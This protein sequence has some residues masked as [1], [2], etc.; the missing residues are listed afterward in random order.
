MRRAK[1]PARG[2]IFLMAGGPGQASTRYFDIGEYGY[3]SVLFRDY[4][5]VTFDPRGTGDS[6]QLS[7]RSAASDI[8]GSRAARIG[9]DCARQLGSRR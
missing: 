8:E 5:L 9:A 1:G 6:N 3:W 4:T 7:C 2:V